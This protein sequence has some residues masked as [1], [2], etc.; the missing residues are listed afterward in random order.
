VTERTA[1]LLKSAFSSV[2]LSQTTKPIAS[3]ESIRDEAHTPAYVKAHDKRNKN[4]T[5]A[6]NAPQIRR[7]WSRRPAGRHLGRSGSVSERNLQIGS[8]K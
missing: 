3:S 6:E 4:D 2:Q 8:S 5:A 7:V 1:L